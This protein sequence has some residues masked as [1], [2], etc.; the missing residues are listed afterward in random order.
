MPRL[1]Q[2]PASSLEP[3]SPTRLSRSLVPLSRGFS[4]SNQIGNSTYRRPYNPRTT[5]I[6]RVWAVPISLATTLGIE[7]SFF[8]WRY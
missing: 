3:L 7:V 4:Y 1:T 8:S 6:V 5:L 2:V